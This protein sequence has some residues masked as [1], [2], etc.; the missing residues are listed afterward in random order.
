MGDRL[1]GSVVL[2][3]GASAGI[4]QAS[5]LALAVRARGSW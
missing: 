4:G 2:V 1:A 5:V 3:T